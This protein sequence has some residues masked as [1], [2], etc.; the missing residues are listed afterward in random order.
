MRSTLNSLV[1][2]WFCF[3]AN[4]T[5]I[6]LLIVILAKSQNEEE[7]CNRQLPNITVP[8]TNGDNGF[9]IKINGNPEKYIPGELYTSKLSFNSFLL[10]HINR[11]L[12]SIKNYLK[13]T[14][15]NFCTLFYKQ[16]FSSSSK[17][18]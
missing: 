14:S 4:Q 9:K 16:F 10:C 5:L 12:Y 6:T 3:F 8:K 13:N 7:Y 18:F 15:S 1:N 17:K 11:S 2:D